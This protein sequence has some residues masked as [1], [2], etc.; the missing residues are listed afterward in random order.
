[1]A[2]EVRKRGAH[3]LVLVQTEQLGRRMYDE[4]PAKYDGQTPLQAKRLI[5]TIDVFI[6]TEAGEGRTYR[7]V[8]PERQAARARAFQPLIALARKRG[9]RNVFLGNGLYPSEERAEQ[10]GMGRDALADMMYHGIDADY[11]QLARTGKQVAAALSAGKELRITNPAGTDLRLRIEGRPVQ[12][13]DGIISAE[14]R[15]RG[16]AALSVWLPAGE[17]YLTPVPGTAEGTLVADRYFYEG[18]LIEGLR[19]EVKGG[20]VVAMSARSGL[21][22]M[23]ARYDAAGP[24]RDLVSVVDLGINPGL[25]VPEGK[26]VNVWSRAGAVTL[27]IGNNSWAGGDNQ[28]DFAIAPEVARATVVVDGREI[29]KDGGLVASPAVAAR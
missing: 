26:A 9:V 6:A 21:D 25:K 19:L 2:V 14:D 7:G 13:S 16:G 5:E 28:T 11:E 17:V 22:P 27:V 1:M 18:A 3:P 24:G 23:K 10:L 29:V 15:K 4:V 12:V 8:P 20:K